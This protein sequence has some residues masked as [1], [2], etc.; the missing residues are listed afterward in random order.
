MPKGIA[1]FD[2]LPTGFHQLREL[3]LP[4]KFT[5]VPDKHDFPLVKFNVF[6]PLAHL[7]RRHGNVFS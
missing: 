1:I 7:S 6:E 3:I 2:R 5:V 4:V